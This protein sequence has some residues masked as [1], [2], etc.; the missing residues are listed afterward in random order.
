VRSILVFLSAANRDE[1]AGFLDSRFVRQ[2][3][4][5][6]LRLAP[7]GDP[8]LY[9]NFIDVKNPDLGDDDEILSIASTALGG[10]PALAIMA[11]VSGRH[12]GDVEVREFAGGLLGRFPGVA[13][14]DFSNRAWTLAEIEA[15]LPVEGMTFF[16]YGGA[17]E[18][19]KVE[20]KN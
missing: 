17:Y 9:I 12:A 2:E 6:W 10:T 8:V 7:A 1:V 11:D 16:D 19:T 13:F 18:R 3:N 4:A 5:P 20:K 14:D 15:G